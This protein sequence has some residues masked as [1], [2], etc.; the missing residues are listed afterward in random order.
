MVQKSRIRLVK[1]V[2]CVW[3]GLEM[4]RKLKKKY[5]PLWWAVSA[6]R[7][8]H[9]HPWK[10]FLL[11]KENRELIDQQTASLMI[12]RRSI[13]YIMG[14]R[15]WYLEFVLFCIRSNYVM[16]NNFTTKPA[17]GHTLATQLNLH[18]AHPLFCI[19]KIKIRLSRWSKMTLDRISSFLIAMMNIKGS[20][21][22]LF[23]S[24]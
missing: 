18:F 6:A 1:H 21:L 8:K 23:W 5:K 11:W 17:N 10:S 19:S 2:A 12:Q 14:Q 24:L 15:R 7:I 13:C 22:L 3:T 16:G 4:M 9:L 20:L